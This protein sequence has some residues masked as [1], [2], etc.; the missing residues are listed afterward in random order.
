MATRC[1]RFIASCASWDEFYRRASALSNDEKGRHFERLARAR[2]RPTCRCSG[3][4]VYQGRTDH[5]PQ[6]RQGA[7][8]HRSSHPARPR[9]RGDRMKAGRRI[10]VWARPARLRQDFG[11]QPSPPCGGRLASRSRHS[12]AKTKGRRRHSPRRRASR[13]DASRADAV[14]A[15]TAAKAGGAEGAR[16]PDLLIANEALSQ[17]SYGP[18][19]MRP[20][21][22]RWR[23][24][25]I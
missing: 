3:A 4:A 12:A 11:G 24:P 13:P 20:P 15:L 23:V 7:R 19:K 21:G 14:N 5:Q 18:A 25:A 2:S 17:L 22:G 16:T 8:H 6:D 1:D 9:R 10:C